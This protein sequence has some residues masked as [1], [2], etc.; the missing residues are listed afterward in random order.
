[1]EECAVRMSLS[2]IE[3]LLQEYERHPD[4]KIALNERIKNIH[5]ADS[6]DKN[7]FERFTPIEK[8]NA[9]FL[10]EHLRDVLGEYA[11]PVSHVLTR[12]Q[13]ERYVTSAMAF[14]H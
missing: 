10:E 5:L 8:E 2:A 14:A 9:S 3:V 6:V 13:L 4:K 12:I 1:M 11:L 7:T